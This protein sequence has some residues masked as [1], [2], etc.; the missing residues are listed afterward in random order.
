M[1][2][3][4]LKQYT[5]EIKTLSPVF[6]GNGKEAGKREYIYDREKNIVY[7]FDTIRLYKALSRKNLTNQ[8]QTHLLND[9]SK[10]DLEKFFYRNKV[11]MR[12]YV[13]WSSYKV[14]VGDKN[15]INHANSNIQMFIKDAV[16]QAYIP[17]SSLKGALR[18]ILETDYILTHQQ[19]FQ[20]EKKQ[21]REEKYKNN[22]KN[23]LSD[24]NSLLENKSFHHSTLP[25]TKLEDMQ[26]D[27]LRGLI[28]GDS[29]YI[30]HSQL[31]ICQKIDVTKDG[32]EN[33]LNVLRECIAPQTVIRF[34]LT[35][36][37]SI[38]QLTKEDI[39]QAVQR[40]YQHYEKS[41]L[42]HYNKA[43]ALLSKKPKFYLGGGAGYPT[44]TVTHALFTGRE[45]T[46]VV[47][48]ILGNTT[49][50]EKHNKD[51]ALGV[52]P[53]MLKCTRYEKRLYQMG[54]CEISNIDI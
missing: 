18:T 23:Y 38:C 12:E 11:S 33:K 36:D 24:G 39:I 4:Y 47:S 34:P 16:G 42:K 5:L 31:C 2:Y 28:V 10:D 1:M 13:N 54:A 50:G 49:S 22:R 14:K 3:S 17:G 53:H 20:S 6:I 7:F 15:L 25:E 41:F 45:A 51:R 8:F 52:S 19:D 44:K 30:P 21:I 48:K 26:N 9:G 35:I 37:T 29:D 40:F 27:K 43:P 32:E 46:E